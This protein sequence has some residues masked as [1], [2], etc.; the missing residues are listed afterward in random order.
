[1]RPFALSR[2]KRIDSF[3]DQC[4]AGRVIEYLVRQLQLVDHFVFQVLDFYFRHSFQSLNGHSLLLQPIQ[5]TQTP[6]ACLIYR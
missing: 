2:P 3:P 6:A 4:L 1:M 5:F